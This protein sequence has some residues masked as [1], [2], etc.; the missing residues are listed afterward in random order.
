MVSSV[1][2]LT[3]EIPDELVGRLEPLQ[4]RLPELLWRLLDSDPKQTT[5]QSKVNIGTVEIAE[6]YLEVLD[7]LIKRPT[8]EEIVEF[9]VSPHAQMRLQVLLE[10]NRSGSLTPIEIAELD[11]YEQLEHLMILLKARARTPIH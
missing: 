7:F 10:K 1:A 2:K 3:I 8:P 9:K 4:S 5:E 6:V 11:V